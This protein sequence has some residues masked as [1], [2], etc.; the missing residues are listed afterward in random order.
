V[1]GTSG[2]DVLSGTTGADILIGGAG[3]DTL[4]GLVGGDTFKW[5]LADRG[6]T[7]SPARDTVADFDTV[8]NSDKLDLRDLLQGETHDAITVGNLQNYL[9]FESAGG[10]TTVQ[11]SSSGGFVNG[12]NAGAVDQTIVLQGVNLLS[13]FST[14]LQVIKDLLD[15]GKL[16]TDATA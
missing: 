5:S 7:A 12:Y 9:H 11:I 1:T 14:D 16:V 15:R 4:A 2:A 6:T 3:N 10:N 13:G 8:I